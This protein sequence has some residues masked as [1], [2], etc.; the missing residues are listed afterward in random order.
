VD[1]KPS[2]YDCIYSDDDYAD[3]S[4]D[5]DDQNSAGDDVYD[6]K[7]GSDFDIDHNVAMY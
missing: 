6:D 7:N 1:L 4:D 5:D 2:I 3:H